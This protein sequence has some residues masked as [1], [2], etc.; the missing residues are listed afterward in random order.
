MAI[1]RQYVNLPAGL[2]TQYGPNSGSI[3]TLRVEPDDRGAVRPTDR[4]EWWCE[5][6]GANNTDVAYI[7]GNR[8]ISPREGS[9]RLTA[10]TGTTTTGFFQAQVTFPWVGGDQ[11]RVKVCRQT[12]RRDAAKTRTLPDTFETWRKIYYTVYYMGAGSFNFFNTV[13]PRIT[14]AFNR[15]FVELER[16]QMVPTLTV[17]SKVN[18]DSA[19]AFM[20]GRAGAIMNLRPTGTGRLPNHASTKPF[21]LAVVIVPDAYET[22]ARTHTE[23]LDFVTGQYTLNYLLFQNAGNTTLRTADCLT[24]ARLRWRGHPAWTD[25]RSHLTLV[26]ANRGSSRLDFDFR[27]VAGLTSHLAARAGNTYSLNIRTIEEK[28]DFVGYS[29]GNLCVV[30][31]ASGVTSALQTFTHEVGHGLNQ[32]VRRESR[33]NAAGSA[34]I[35]A[36]V[37]PR[38]HTDNFGG[39][40]PHCWHNAALSTAN[41]PAG[42]TAVYRY[43][44]AGNLCT[45]YF[46]DEPHCDPDG[47]FCAYCEPRLKRQDLGTNRQSNA[48]WN[49]YG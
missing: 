38:W 20:N 46:A 48:Y 45:M 27:T 42:L 31:T 9:T 4:A 19:N 39:R 35:A 17:I 28:H 18:T 47:R 5:P 44:G 29:V 1:I 16:V 30:E 25:V 3:R 23:A 43:G 37:N 10:L 21:H 26:S 24:T 49:Y 40:G 14:D 33:W 2:T 7:R 11:Y 41:P 34:E 12:D 22:A 6:A 32:A 15:C 8:R 13:E 36:D